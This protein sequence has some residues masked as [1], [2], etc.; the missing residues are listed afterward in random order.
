MDE[1]AMTIVAL[2][3]ADGRVF[4]I[5]DGLISRGANRV[6]EQDQKIIVFEPRY[7]IPRAGL[8]HFSHF[9]DF[10]GGQFGLAYAGN[11]TLI[12]TIV[13]KFLRVVEHLMYLDRSSVGGKPEIYSRENYADYFRGLSYDDSYNSSSDELIPI[14]VNLLSNVLHRVAKSA[15]LD[16]AKNAMSHP[17]AS[18][19]VFGLDEP[20]RS[21]T[22]RAQV[23]KYLTVANGEVG[24]QRYSVLPWSLSCIGDATVIPG[25]IAAVEADN[26][27]S[28]R[29]PTLPAP[30]LADPFDGWLGQ[31]ASDSAF[32]KNRE[33]TIQRYVLAIIEQDVGTIGGQCTIA[34][35][36]VAGRFNVSTIRKENIS[37]TLQSMQ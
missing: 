25:L 32:R 28:S 35:S 24:Y 1:V 16:F 21:Q 26:K 4:V 3:H 17:D 11:F 22:S 13:K 37:A 12:S 9:D 6:I 8:G 23:L 30:Q 18:F 2:H 5:A 7:R 31:T 36:A 14:T 10:T 15:C 33:H 19:F 29:P 27:Y 34:E 20:T